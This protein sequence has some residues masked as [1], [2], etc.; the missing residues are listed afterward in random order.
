MA[1]WGDA[2]LL[3]SGAPVT[4][5][6]D[7]ARDAA[8]E[9]LRNAGYHKSDPSV[10]ER[11]LD[12]IN[13]HITSALDSIG[14]SGGTSGT[15]GL[16]FFV[17]VALLIAAAL[18]WRLGA[19]GRNARTTPEVFGTEG[20]RTAA[21]H[22]AEA[23]AH[24]AAGRWDEAVREQMRALVRSLEERT[25]LDGRPGRTA[26]EAAAEAG[27]S[28][29]E[30]AEALAAAART[31]DDVAYGERTADR[32]SYELLHDLDRKLERTRPTHVTTA[33]EAA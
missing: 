18:W 28:L 19:P 3:A 25:L 16:V 21:Q 31:F 23:S 14:G 33:G 32:A 26:D 5:P 6:R 22:R 1:T 12:W 10:V 11:A 4:L 20:P 17:I 13:D 15:T 7:P 29:P 2:L 8:R 9:E 30:H 27:R 24:A